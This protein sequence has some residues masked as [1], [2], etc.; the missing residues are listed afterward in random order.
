[1]HIAAP[2]WTLACTYNDHGIYIY[3]VAIM[4]GERYQEMGVE[5]WERQLPSIS[6]TIQHGTPGG[7][8]KIAIPKAE[9][10]ADDAIMAEV[11]FVS[12][13]AEF[14]EVAFAIRL[15]RYLALH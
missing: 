2:F 7:S 15:L 8:E 14:R 12:G 6:H 3:M 10:R 5:W 13:A 9:W 4:L 11:V 1:M